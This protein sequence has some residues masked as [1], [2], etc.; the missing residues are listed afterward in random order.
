M[1]RYRGL[2]KGKESF[3]MRAT[4]IGPDGEGWSI[5]KMEKTQAMVVG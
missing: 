4:V 5:V 2:L 3:D 1:T